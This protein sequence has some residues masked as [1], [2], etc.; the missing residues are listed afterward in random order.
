M[1]RSDPTLARE[2]VLALVVAEPR[3]GWALQRELSPEGR[4]GRAW[5]LSR[6][7]TYR[8]IDAVV[9]DGLARRGTPRDGGGADRVVVTATARGKRHSLAWLDEPVTHLRDVRTELLVKLMLREQLGLDTDV[10]LAGQRR[11]F[12]PLIGR[13]LASADTGV[14]ATWRREN[15]DAVR[16][17]LDAVQPSPAGPPTVS[18]LADSVG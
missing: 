13:M 10:F 16:R 11:V 15:A 3:H 2:V 17:F 14:V 6:Q 4:I 5:S 18:A 12:D 8:A 9:A 1:A 7:L